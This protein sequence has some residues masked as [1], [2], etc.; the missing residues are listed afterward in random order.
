M[1]PFGDMMVMI[2]MH[3]WSTAS[4]SIARCS[5][6]TRYLGLQ[7]QKVCYLTFLQVGFRVMLVVYAMIHSGSAQVSMSH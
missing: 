1:S 7:N 2:C 4:L 3:A 6:G 5:S